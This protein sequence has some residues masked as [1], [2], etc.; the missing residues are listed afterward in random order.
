M[1]NERFDEA[2]QSPEI[3]TIDPKT[4]NIVAQ[5]GHFAAGAAIVLAFGLWTE[6]RAAIAWIVLAVVTFIKEFWWDYT[7]ETESVRGSSLLDWFVYQAGALCAF[8]LLLTR[9]R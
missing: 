5:L 3:V 4:F 2:Y 9:Y 8:A 6:R 7:Y 1:K